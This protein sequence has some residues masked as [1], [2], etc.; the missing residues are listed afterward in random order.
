MS[1]TLSLISSL[2]FLSYLSLYLSKIYV[3]PI[4]DNMATEATVSKE[5]EFVYYISTAGSKC[6]LV[7]CSLLIEGLF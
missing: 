3:K 4:D 2:K 6:L 1:L 7:Y 5:V